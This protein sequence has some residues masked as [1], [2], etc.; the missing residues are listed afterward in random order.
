MWQNFVYKFF[1]SIHLPVI[2]LR[3]ITNPILLLSNI[4]L[5][6]GIRGISI[7]ARRMNRATGNNAIS[8]A[9]CITNGYRKILLL[10]SYS[11]SYYNTI[12]HWDA[13]TMIHTFYSSFFFCMI[14]NLF[15]FFLHLPFVLSETFNIRVYFT[16]NIDNVKWG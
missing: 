7:A 3:C 5:G 16:D 11:S 9:A 2:R 15:I 1:S 12:V 10:G 13:T 4:D 6:T 8:L 14:S